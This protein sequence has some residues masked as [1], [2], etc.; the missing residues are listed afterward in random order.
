MAPKVTKTT[1]ADPTKPSGAPVAAKG[2]N[3]KKHRKARNAGSYSSYIYKVLKSVHP[4]VGIS[5]KA[6]LAMN[7]FV[8]DL[9]ERVAFEAS[10][11]VRHNK[12]HTLTS[13]EIQTAVRL[14]LPGEL[15][16]HAVSDGTKA[17][18]KYSASRLDTA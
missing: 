9:F 14:A 7:S 10:Q 5:K 16:K 3:P 6:M 13:R 18:T 2:G 15:A 12:K 4:N 11:L 17:V 8:T 1:T